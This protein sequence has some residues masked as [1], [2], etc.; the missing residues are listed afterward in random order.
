MLHESR[1]AWGQFL[2][3]L[4][5]HACMF[6]FSRTVMLLGLLPSRVESSVSARMSLFG[7]VSVHCLC[8]R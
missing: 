5:G 4:L 2:Q 8:S 6:V 1:V 7:S 3:L